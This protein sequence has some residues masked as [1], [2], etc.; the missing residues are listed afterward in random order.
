M[1][2]SVKSNMVERI[3]SWATQLF[4]V[5]SLLV[6][7]LALY[8]P[9]LFLWYGKE[10][11]SYGLGVIMLGMGITLETKDFIRVWKQ[12]KVLGLGVFS[13][14]L[15]MPA[16]GAF[17]AWAL[18][19]PTEMAVGLILVS[20]CPGGTASNVIVFLAKAN[21]AL[22][23]SLTLV[24]TTLAI[25]LTPF[26]TNFYGGHFVPVDAWGLLKSILL[27]VIFPLTIGIIWKSNFQKT[28][29]E[30]S[31]VSPFLSV[32]FILL[33]VG[34]VISV[35]SDIILG[36]WVVLLFSV[37]LLH[38]G[39]FFLGF[40]FGKIFKQDL[41]ECRTLGIE[42]G[43]QNSGLAMALASKHFSHFP[44]VPAPCA[45]SAVVHCLIGSFV[46]VWWNRKKIKK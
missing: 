24:S 27:I 29:R 33:I 22:S 15:I 30:V 3:A 1:L 25:F 13:Q 35:K 38:S 4:P 21:V 31:K 39:G 36:N 40:V 19:L 20:C 7:F 14:F 5:W 18:E 43:M 16:W 42:V 46:A 17:L 32:L 8:E 9:S 12:P 10:A 6:G 37:F 11:I 26:L 45:L 41:I 34:Y 28:A 23:V 2:V 44:M